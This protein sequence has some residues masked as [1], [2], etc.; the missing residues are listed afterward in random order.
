MPVG[1]VAWSQ[2]GTVIELAEADW[3]KSIDVMLKASYLFGKHAF[4]V[5]MKQGGGKMVNIASVHS[6]AVHP[7][8]PVYAAAKECR[9]RWALAEVGTALSLCA[10][11]DYSRI[12][13]YR[14]D[15]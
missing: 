13:S 3:H 15:T 7:R 11:H 4:P 1:H 9:R 12:T 6:E 2:Y 5:I 14:D 10:P 8:Y